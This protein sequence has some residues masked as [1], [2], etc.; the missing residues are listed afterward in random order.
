MYF[1]FCIGKRLCV[2]ETFSRNLLF[3]LIGALMQNFTVHA[4]VAMKNV[5]PT[6]KITGIVQFPN[7]FWV[8]FTS[9]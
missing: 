3:L 6:G 1:H 7:D 4:P 8:T 2:A 5:K 9:R